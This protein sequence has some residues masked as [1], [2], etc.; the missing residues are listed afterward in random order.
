MHAFAKLLSV[1]NVPDPNPTVHGVVIKVEASGICRSDWHGWQGHDADIKVL[2]HV[3]GHELA[4]TVEAVGRVVKRWQPGD[5]VTLPFSVGC[6]SCA[7][8]ISGNHQICDNYFQPGFT[9]WGSFA[10]YVAIPYADVNLV[11]LPE[12]L[13]FVEAASLGCR[14]IT[15][16]RGVV[17]QGRV[18]AG[19]WVTV[20]GCGGVG[21]SAI[22]I[23]DALGAQVIGIDI[24]ESKLA[25]ARKVG[26]TNTVNANEVH[27]VPSAVR[28]LSGGGVHVSVDALGSVQTCRQAIQSLRKR[29]RHVQIGLLAGPDHD[30]PL[31]MGLVI[32]NELEIVGSHGMQAHQYAPMLDMIL[33]GKLQPQQLIGGTVTLDEAP[34]VLA[35]MGEFKTQGIVVIDQFG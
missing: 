18:Q 23:A 15:S 9:G 25:M 3:P 4:G 26:A 5:R 27:D 14:F 32:A 22:M 13:S 16:F 31:P 8:C 1:E 21:L 17:A 12:Q 10:E 6:G 29:G 20:Y 28:D 35:S 30:P 19:E 34:G 2:P 7:Q 24:D 11:R 33:S